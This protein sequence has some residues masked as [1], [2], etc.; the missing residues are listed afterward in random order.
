MCARV[1]VCVRVNAKKR[2]KKKEKKVYF[3]VGR[4]G[5]RRAGNLNLKKIL[6]I[7]AIRK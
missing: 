1:L 7:A 2:E 6:S 4:K 3:L 5:N